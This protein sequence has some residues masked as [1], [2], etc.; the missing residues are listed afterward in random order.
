MTEQKRYTYVSYDKN[1]GPPHPIR[2][3]HHG[4]NAPVTGKDWIEVTDDEL[5]T[6]VNLSPKSIAF[7][8]DKKKLR[9][10]RRVD[11]VVETP[12]IDADDKDEGIIKVV[13]LDPGEE[14][15]IKVREYTVALPDDS[16]SF[17]IRITSDTDGIIP[18]RL[19]DTDKYF[20]NTKPR[21]IVARRPR[22][23][24]S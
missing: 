6:S 19:L 14:I 1:V 9:E 7:D 23:R 22:A 5:V 10:K 15:K 16:G 3:V 20:V 11:I 17:E 4:L 18:I 13:G 21:N 2:K 8:P 24:Q 12:V